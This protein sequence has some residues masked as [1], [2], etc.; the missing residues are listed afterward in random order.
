MGALLLQSPLNV[1]TTTTLVER[2]LFILSVYFLGV[3]CLFAIL[4]SVLQITASDFPNGIFKLCNYNQY[5][6][7]M[8]FLFYLLQLTLG[9]SFQLHFQFLLNSRYEPYIYSEK[10]KTFHDFHSAHINIHIYI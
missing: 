8:I 7:D 6:I 2:E 9:T 1:T 3:F 4:L 10:I 5:I